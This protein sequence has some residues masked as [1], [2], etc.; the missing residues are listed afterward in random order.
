MHTGSACRRA[1]GGAAV[2]AAV[3]FGACGGGEQVAGP[4]ALAFV[5][6]PGTTQ[7][8]QPITPAVQVA[9]QDAFAHTVTSAT[10]AVT[11]TIATNP[12]GGTLSGPTTANA[13]S[14]VATFA[15]LTIDRPGTGY[16]LAATAA[17][18]GGTTS[19]AFDIRLVFARVSA[20]L[21]HTCG[22]TTAG[23]AYCWG[24]DSTGQLGDGTRLS[25]FSP[26][27]VLGGL[28]FAVVSA[29]SAHTCGVTTAGAAY[30]WGY[31]PSGELGDGTTTQR[32]SPVAVRG[33]LSFAGLDDGRVGNG[34]STRG[35]PAH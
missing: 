24:G 1:G 4:R 35:A 34:G 18:L 22:V 33:G 23:A 25:R 20:G 13:V 15:N 5:V 26:V 31:N 11:L 6:Q 19:A 7:G 12:G 21:Q 9:I 29:G 28:S 10:N 3:V 27:L 17:T 16:T 8:A 32:T 14:G 2:L 30:C